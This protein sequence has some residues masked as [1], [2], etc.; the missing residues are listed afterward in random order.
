MN[1]PNLDKTIMSDIDILI[2]IEELEGL[3]HYLNQT[4]I[5]FD[6]GAEYIAYAFKKL[7]EKKGV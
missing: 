7:L 4:C 3:A 2:K 1:R 5:E 6:Q